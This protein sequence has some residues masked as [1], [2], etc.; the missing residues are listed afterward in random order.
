MA[1]NFFLEEF[2]GV[3]KNKK[4]LRKFKKKQ[5]SSAIKLLTNKQMKYSI[6]SHKQQHNSA[7]NPNRSD[8]LKRAQTSKHGASTIRIIL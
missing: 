8:T 3:S 1:Y 2:S 7:K 5:K 4:V 6:Q